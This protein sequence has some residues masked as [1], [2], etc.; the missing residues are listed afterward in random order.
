MESRQ[1]SLGLFVTDDAYVG[2]NGYSLKLDGLDVGFNDRARARAIVMHGASYVD[3]QLAATQGR[4]GRSWGCPALRTAVATK[5]IDRI[6]G[7]GVIF[8]Y[9]PDQ[10]WLKGSRFLQRRY[11]AKTFGKNLIFAVSPR[12]RRTFVG[13]PTFQ[14]GYLGEVEESE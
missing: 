13:F 6:R 2:S 3:P 8:S 12:R 7:G 5:V 14:V 10:E 11:G 9:Y 4:I 1:T